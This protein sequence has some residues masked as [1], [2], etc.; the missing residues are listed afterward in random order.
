MNQH[1]IQKVS[2]LTLVRN[3]RSQLQNLMTGLLRSQLVPHELVIVY[4]NEAPYGDLPILPFP[5]QILSVKDINQKLPLGKARN[6]AAF[7]ATGDVLLFLDVDCI[8]SGNLLEEMLRVQQEK[9]GL[10]MGNLRYLRKGW[11]NEYETEADLIQQSVLHPD[12]PH[13]TEGER[14]MMEDYG[15]FWSLCFSITPVDF[16]TIGGFDEQFRNYGAEDT[17]FGFTAREKGI[18]FGLISAYCYHQYHPVCR[19]PLNN[20]DSIITNAAIFKDK[21]GHWAMGSWLKDFS[22]S[23]YIQWTPDSHEIIIQREPTEAD[24]ANAVEDNGKG[25]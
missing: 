4:M 8:P 2:V 7:H 1:A 19:P 10:W 16:A 5:V 25:F 13:V 9:P 20:F 12:R 11:Q 15:Y 17:D 14:L 21:W 18:P 6:K 23:G 24:V 22:D 3:R